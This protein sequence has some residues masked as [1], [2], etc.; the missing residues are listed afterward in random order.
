[1]AASDRPRPPSVERVLAGV[2]AQLDG[3][4]DPVVAADVVREIVAEERER[5]VTGA[6]PETRTRLRRPRASDS[7]SGRAGGRTRWCRSSTRRA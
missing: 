1:M 5:L 4:V 2:R 6:L 3:S 7:V